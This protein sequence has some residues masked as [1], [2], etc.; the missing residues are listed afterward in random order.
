MWPRGFRIA[1][2]T[3]ALG[4]RVD[5]DVISPEDYTGSEA[6]SKCLRH[7]EIAVA[8]ETSPGVQKK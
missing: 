2:S 8:V 3:F 7:K 4:E 5:C 6:C 1:D